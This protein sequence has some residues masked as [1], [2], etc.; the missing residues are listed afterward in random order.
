MSSFQEVTARAA[1]KLGEAFE[2]YKAT[3]DA[4][5]KLEKQLKKQLEEDPHYLHLL[6]SEKQLKKKRRELSEEL[7]DVKHQQELM[8]KNLDEY[9]DLEGFIEKTEGAYIA[10][11][12]EVLESLA[13]ELSAQGIA[14]EIHFKNGDLMLIISRKK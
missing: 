6:D 13:R 12:T 4:R 1:E 10:R 9:E 14:A 11:K 8:M 3:K 5:K 7:A 2:N